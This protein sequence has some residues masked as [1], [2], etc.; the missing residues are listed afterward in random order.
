MKSRGGASLTYG[1]LFARGVAAQRSVC[2]F[3]LG[4]AEGFV[5]FLEVDDQAVVGD[6]RV[7]QAERR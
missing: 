7:Y 5:V 1:K 6:V 3:G 4:R 2:G